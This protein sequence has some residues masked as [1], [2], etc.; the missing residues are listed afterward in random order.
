MFR[1]SGFGIVTTWGF[2]SSIFQFARLEFG[3]VLFR[4]IRRFTFRKLQRIGRHRVIVASVVSGRLLI[5]GRSRSVCRLGRGINGFSRSINRFGRGINGRRCS[6]GALVCGLISDWVVG[7]SYGSAGVDR[8]DS[9]TGVN[10]P[11][12]SAGVGRSSCSTGVARPYGSA[13]ISRSGR[14]VARFTWVPQWVRRYWVVISSVV[15]DWLTGSR[16]VAW[17]WSRCRCISG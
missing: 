1:V 3:T 9:C 17:A 14:F 10:R 4:R 2:E 13:G 7:W 8:P 6:R 12:G 16:D 5:A 11:Y 15:A